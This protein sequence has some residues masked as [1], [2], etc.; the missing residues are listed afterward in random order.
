MANESVNKQTAKPTIP[1]LD[2]GEADNRKVLNESIIVLYDGLILDS[3]KMGLVELKYI[4]NSSVS[5]L[6]DIQSA[7]LYLDDDSLKT[8]Y[9]VALLWKPENEL[10][11]NTLLEAIKLTEAKKKLFNSDLD[12]TKDF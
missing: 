8:I 1:L 6:L 12:T 7:L 10:T 5:I 2:I 4:D 9:L 3:E 11:K